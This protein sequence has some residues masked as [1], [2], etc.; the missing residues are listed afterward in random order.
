MVIFN[1][2]VSLPEGIHVS[3]NREKDETVSLESGA[4]W[5]TPCKVVTKWLEVVLK[6]LLS[7]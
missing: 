2:Y 7:T 4:N 6:S 3:F 5:W 1:S